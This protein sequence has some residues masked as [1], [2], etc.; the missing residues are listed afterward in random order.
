MPAKSATTPKARLPRKNAESLIAESYLLRLDLDPYSERN[1][2]PLLSAA[3][4]WRDALVA[5]CH[6]PKDAVI[7]FHGRDH[8]FICRAV[9][10]SIL[11]GEFDDGGEVE[12][13]AVAGILD[14][15]GA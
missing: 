4:H 15:V 8:I 3:Q 9:Q 11:G 7:R 6:A 10:F 12:R 2:P 13:G 14:V 1:F 5:I